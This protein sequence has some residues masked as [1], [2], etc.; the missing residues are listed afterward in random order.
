MMKQYKLNGVLTRESAARHNTSAVLAND[1]DRRLEAVG[2][3]SPPIQLQLPSGV[4]CINGTETA[5][6]HSTPSTSV[7]NIPLA[8]PDSRKQITSVTLPEKTI[9]AS[10]SLSSAP[11]SDEHTKAKKKK[12]KKNRKK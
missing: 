10:S 12:Y 2:Y 6:S 9:P 5:T 11:A 7:A 3:H 8:V 4:Q 1:Q